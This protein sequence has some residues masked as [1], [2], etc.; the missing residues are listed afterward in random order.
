MLSLCL[1]WSCSE[2]KDGDFRRIEMRCLGG[3]FVREPGKLSQPGEREEK[4]E[5]V[6]ATDS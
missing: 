3:S 1:C 5:E 6:W 2:G 4:E